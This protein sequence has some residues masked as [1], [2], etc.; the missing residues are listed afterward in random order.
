MGFLVSCQI[1]LMATLVPGVRV[2]NT[3]LTIGWNIGKEATEGGLPLFKGVLRELGI[4]TWIANGDP[5]A[6]SYLGILVQEICTPKIGTPGVWEMQG[7]PFKDCQKDQDSLY[8]EWKIRN[9]LKVVLNHAAV[10]V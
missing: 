10:A 8:A 2:R 5:E 9:N 6:G 3:D 4:L 7:L 1:H